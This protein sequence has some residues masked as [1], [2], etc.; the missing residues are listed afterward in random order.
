METDKKIV[1]VV[2]AVICD[3]IN[4]P[5]KYLQRREDMGNLKEAGNFREEK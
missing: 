1:N 2:A 5:R 4:T 3:N